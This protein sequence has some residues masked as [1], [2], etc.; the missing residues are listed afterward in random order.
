METL[1]SVVGQI[2]TQVST[3]ITL[4]SETPLL[5]ITLAGTFASIAISI[6]MQLLGF[7]RRNKE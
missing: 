4:I 5:L 6:A 2:W 7:H 1:I 3:V